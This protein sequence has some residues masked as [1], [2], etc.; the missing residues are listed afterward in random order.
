MKKLS[1]LSLLIAILF[2]GSVMAQQPQVLINDDFEAYTVGNNL[3]VEA[4]AAGNVWWTTWSGAPGSS[5]D[6]VIA[7]YLGT[8][9]GYLT[10]NVDQ[11]LSLGNEENGAY[12]LEFDILV[13]TGKNAYFNILH[14][15]NPSGGN[16]WAMES[17]L[18][19]TGS[20]TASA[21]TGCI[22]VGGQT[23]NFAV[24]YDG[25]MHF[26]LHVDTD[27]DVAEYYYTA[28]DAK[29][30]ELIHTWTWSYSATSAQS[31]GRKLAAMDFYPPLDAS[32]SQFYLDNFSYTKTSG[33]TAPVMIVDTESINT[34]A[35]EDD[36]TSV[37]VTISNEEGTSMGD[38]TAW[39]DFGASQG[40]TAM[41]ELHWD[42]EPSS[43]SS[44]VGF[45]ITSPKSYEGAVMFPGATYA[46]AAMGTSIVSA[47][48][49]MVESS[50]GF[51]LE[52]N[53]PLIFRVY[54]QGLNGQPGEVLAEK[55]VP[56]D[57][58]NHED[59]TIA[60]FD[61]PVV[62][63]GFNAWVAVEFTQKVDG[64][65][66]V[67]DKGTQNPNG[68]YVR[69]AGGGAFELIEEEYGNLH[70]RAN[71]QGE[72]VPA[73]W[74]VLSA[75][76]G[77]IPMGAE[78][79]VTIN[80]NTIGLSLGDSVDAELVILT[81]DEEHAEYTIPMTLTVDPDAV[82]EN[83]ESAFKVYP[84]PTNG[85]VTVEGENI[86]AIAIYSAAGQLINVVNTTTVDMSAYGTG[87]YFFNIVDSANNTT[88]QRVVVK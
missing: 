65:A 43:N 58:I 15:F 23:I 52:E 56:Y 11:V 41:T 67:V 37:E 4:Q 84:N 22:K 47:Q 71:I 86:A 3:A 29:A 27:A 35:P 79:T 1:L 13:P 20:G 17:Y 30:E 16:T 48:Y 77:S 75:T 80:F 36:F 82:I 59:W 68:A 78:E 54:R 55:E 50:S 88:V 69:N 12:D 87:V 49:L 51:G 24:V 5:E 33:D 28:P 46:G 85:K 74:A 40:G 62:L 32:T 45:N 72:P 76:E 34:W 21:N 25:W 18:H 38:W 19:M 61:T 26:R 9:C 66:L 44:L 10:Y 31:V 70:L 63:S 6:G 14:N 81:S 60:T 8:K 73:T 57:Q 39:I 7:S 64:Y 42:E 53:T 83:A 2:G